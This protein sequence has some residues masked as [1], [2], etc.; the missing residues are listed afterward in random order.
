[1]CRWPVHPLHERPEARSTAAAA[2]RQRAPWCIGHH[3]N[4]LGGGSQDWIDR[5]RGLTA[6]LTGNP[7]PQSQQLNITLI[8]GVWVRVLEAMGYQER[9]LLEVPV[10][11]VQAPPEL[12]DAVNLLARAQDA[13]ARGDY[14]DAV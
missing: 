11:D 14:R 9:L 1:V 3:P 4:E 12:R 10:P 2:T 7:R 6:H 13:I 5:E 8:L